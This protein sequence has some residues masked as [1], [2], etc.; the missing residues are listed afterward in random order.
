MCAEPADQKQAGHT[1]AEDAAKGVRG[2]DR[3]E[4]PAAAAL[5][6][7]QQLAHHRQRAAHQAGWRQQ[8]QRGDT[9]EQPTPQRQA[10][11]KGGE[12]R[13]EGVHAHAKVQAQQPEPDDFV[14]QRARPAE[15]EQ[16]QRSRM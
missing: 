11:H 4:I 2:I 14:D 5:V 12:H 8:H 9:P 6:A 13:A 15:E 1:R 16:R 3:A 7:R 10:A